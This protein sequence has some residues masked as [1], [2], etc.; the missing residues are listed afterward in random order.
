MQ[1]F[2]GYEYIK[3]DIANQAGLD[4]ETWDTRIAWVDKNI[5][6][7]E[8][9]KPN[10]D[11]PILFMKGVKALRDAQA[12]KPTGFIMGLD[13][14]AS[15]LQ[16]MSALIGCHQ[17]AIR[18][19]LI[20]TG[21]RE[22]IYADVAEKMSGICNKDISTAMVK[23]PVMT[24][25]YGSKQQPKNLFGED[26]PELDAFYETLAE[27]LPGAMEVMDDIQG[28]WNP[29]G[30]EHEWTLPDGHTSLV[31]VMGP[32]DKKIE[33]DELV[34]D[35]G[36]HATFTHRAYINTPNDKGL[37]LAANVIHSIDGYIV[38]EMIRRADAQGFELLT[39]H[40]SFW[41][42]PNYMNEVRKNYTEILAEIADSNLLGDILNEITGSSLQYQKL[43]S[44]LSC[45]IKTSNYALS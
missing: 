13:A 34:S 1:T 20:N 21:K 43:S 10:V 18:V 29:V 41:S 24:T 40:D 19:N 22:A 42:S 9:M 38:R 4:K 6:K 45:S 32:K 23:H 33:I 12:H 15:G 3:I 44:N 17:T 11:E 25:F 28:C 8:K 16:I 26:S 36:A 14:T 7:L 27:L 35:T 37:S 30:L 31:R 2:T 5:D 39:I